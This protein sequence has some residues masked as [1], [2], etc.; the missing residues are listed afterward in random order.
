MI[1][2]IFVCILL[3][4]KMDI[5]YGI[6]GRFHVKLMFYLSKSAEQIR[7]EFGKHNKFPKYNLVREHTKEF[8]IIGN[9]I[10][11]AGLRALICAGSSSSR[12][13]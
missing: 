6:L 4:L 11:R 10:I 8:A 9:V 2:K 7:V 1:K 5:R 12:F 13:L 3:N